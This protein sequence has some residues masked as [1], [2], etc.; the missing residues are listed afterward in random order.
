MAIDTLTTQITVNKE[1]LDALK[2]A[3]SVTPKLRFTPILQNILM[4]VAHE[5]LLIESTDLAL[6]FQQTIHVPDLRVEEP[7][8]V[9]ITRDAVKSIKTGAVITLS[10]LSYRINLTSYQT[11]DAKEYP[12]PP[13]LFDRSDPEQFA[14]STTV[15]DSYFDDLLACS[16]CAAESERRPVL[17]AISHL[18][19]QLRG[20]DG[21][22]MLIATQGTE[23]EHEILVPAYSAALLKKA[24][25]RSEQ[26]TMLYDLTHVQYQDDHHRVN[27]RQIEGNYPDV[28]RVVPVRGLLHA[29]NGVLDHTA[30]WID[31]CN[32]AIQ[33]HDLSNKAATKENRNHDYTLRIQGDGK[34][35]D[36]FAKRDQEFLSVIPFE[37]DRKF[38]F[39]VNAKYLKD[40]LQAVGDHSLFFKPN[41]ERDALVL[42]NDSRLALVMPVRID[43]Q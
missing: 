1:I 40:A 7:F 28:R 8:S 22:R 35:V 36:F 4:T 6:W 39:A 17:G 9:L 23:W 34:N 25:G 37:T 19:N 43:Q 15:N 32:A 42:E 29:T 24:F 33:I 3:V 38:K 30:A 10:P 2:L 11:V 31:A 26:V 13:V 12:I 16:I 5:K 21:H 41:H 27:V 14:A 20:T 18:Q